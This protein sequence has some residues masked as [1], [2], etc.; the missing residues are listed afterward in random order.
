[1]GIKLKGL[2][3]RILDN[4]INFKF[5]MTTGQIYIYMFLIIPSVYITFYVFFTFLN[6]V[7]CNFMKR[8]CNEHRPF[9][10]RRSQATSLY[11]LKKVKESGTNST[12]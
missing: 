5:K 10:R 3:S 2:T 11:Y 4:I 7:Y 9:D 8:L 12:F 1:M 6:K